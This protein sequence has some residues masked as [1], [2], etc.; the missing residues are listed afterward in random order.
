M[1]ARSRPTS[2]ARTTTWLGPSPPR[3]PLR[4]DVPWR[5]TVRVAPHRSP[6]RVTRNSSG[7]RPGGM[8][9]TGFI[10]RATIKLKRVDRP[11]CGGHGQDP[12][13]RRDHGRARR[14]R[15]EVRLHGRLVRRL[16]H[17]PPGPVDHHSGD[18][19]SLGD[20][21]TA[22][23][24]PFAFNPRAGWLARL[25]PPGLMNRLLDPAGQRGLVPKAPR[26]REGELQTIS[27]FFHPLD[28]IKN[29]NR[30]Y[31]PGGF[32]QYQYVIPF[33]A[34]AAVRL[35]SRWSAPTA[36]RASSPC[37]SVWARPTRDCC[38]S[39]SRAGRWPSTSRPA[40]RAW[41]R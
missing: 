20:L 4:Y 12:R 38:P 26:L 14:A 35:S 30:V 41:A 11:L 36:P 21:T 17:R 9:L 16:D 6:R 15:R 28:G 1:A 3:H 18:F 37:S 40:P 34:K 23:A 32:R 5:R 29:W 24:H 22:S 33:S 25:L 19:A 39:R 13:R 2:T 31:G 8:G 7:R 10:T 27:Q